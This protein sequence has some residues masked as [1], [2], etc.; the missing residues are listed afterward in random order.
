MNEPHVKVGCEVVIRKGN[1]ILLGKRKNIYGDGTWALP[2]GH[3][4]PNERLVD[5]ICRE[6]KE[7][8]DGNVSPTDLKLVSIVDG[9]PGANGNTHFIHV[10]FE[11]LDPAFEPQLMEPDM[12]A[13]WRYFDLSALPE[14]L[15]PPHKDIFANYLAQRL[16]T[17]E[18]DAAT[19]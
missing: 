5:A 12:C 8:L 14:E 3:L 1:Q 11:L 18:A 15:F 9:I 6:I 2:G 16:Y 7:E 4:E 19:L 10:T 13:E 17:Y